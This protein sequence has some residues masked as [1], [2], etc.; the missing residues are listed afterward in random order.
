MV[1]FACPIFGFVITTYDFVVGF[2][3]LGER[4]G[5][6]GGVGSSVGERRH[7]SKYFS[8]AGVRLRC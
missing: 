3:I 8:S 7:I 6:G 5:S 2:L 1:H 4:G